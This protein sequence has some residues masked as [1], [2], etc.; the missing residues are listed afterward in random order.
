MSIT[1]A[2]PPGDPDPLVMV[3]AN[4]A[5]IAQRN[6]TDPDAAA[7]AERVCEG[8]PALV[9]QRFGEVTALWPAQAILHQLE[10]FDEDVA[11]M[12]GVPAGFRMC[13]VAVRLGGPALVGLP[14]PEALVLSVVHAW[15]PPS[16]P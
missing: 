9:Q 14:A 5:A 6:P 13:D 11:H 12:A 8:L 16:P 15:V 7:H 3:L 10:L 4:R 2:L 1:V